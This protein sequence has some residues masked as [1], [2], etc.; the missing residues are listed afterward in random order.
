MTGILD[1]TIPVGTIAGWFMIINYPQRLP[2]PQLS[3]LHI[4]E[5]FLDPE[6]A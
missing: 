3:K 5:V 2:F 6:R 1:I 4:I